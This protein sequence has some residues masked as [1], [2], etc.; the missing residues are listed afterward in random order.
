MKLKARL[1]VIVTGILIVVVAV[2][3]TI[4]LSRASDIVVG[5]SRRSV[6]R[7]GAQETALI[8]IDC[9]RYMQLLRTVVEIMNDFENMDVNMRRERYN[10]ILNSV[11][12]SEEQLVAVFSVWLPDALDGMDARYAGETGYTADGQYAPYFTRETG[13][14]KYLTYFNVPF[15]VKTLTGPRADKEHIGNPDPF[16]IKGAAAYVIRI[17]VPVISRRT[18]KVVGLVGATINIDFMQSIVEATINSNDD[19]AAMTVYSDNGT[20]VATGYNPEHI[21]K[22]LKDAEENLYHENT[23]K[24]MDAVLHGQK[25]QLNESLTA[26]ATNLEINVLPFTISETGVSWAVMIGTPQNKI[27]APVRALTFYTIIIAVVVAVTVAVII[28][29]VAGNIAKPIIGMT[30]MAKA[31]ADLKFDIEIKKNRNDEI[32]DMQDA[33]RII[34]DNLQKTMEDINTELLGKQANIT[35]NLKSS[36]N[37]SSDGLTVITRH[38]DSVQKKTDIQMGSVD[39]TAESVEEIV[40]HI[41]SLEEAVEVQ[42]QSISKSSES[43]EYLVR[44]IDSVRTI[45]G[46]A[47]HTT[48]NLSASSEVGRKMLRQLTEELARIAEQSAFLE[49]ANST[50]VNI[51]SQTNIL[52]MNAAIEAAHAGESGKGFAVVAGEVRKLAESSNKESASISN[53][54]KAMRTGIEKIRHVS[55]QTV[56]TLESMFT[57][58]TAM[59]MSFNTVNAA[60]EAQASNGA[61]ILDAITVLRDTT[62]QV[63]GGSGEI[64]NQSGLIYKVVEKLKNISAEVKESFLDVQKAAKDIAVSLEIAK[65]IS[66]GR[67]LTCPDKPSL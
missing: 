11:I 19:I 60:V 30:G 16:T 23:D 45:V 40:K 55:D 29:F 43:I 2:L 1:C 59:R 52:A 54:I 67:F 4:I 50:L 35:S 24:V 32:G 13:A 34:K 28:F 42:G 61:Q 12:E 6:E 66:E 33:L 64:Q 15:S 31:L 58:V 39:E 63:R 47:S 25:I 27:L 41:N 7:L 57:E 51:A 46:Q 14:L 44:D 17:I 9:E 3:S 10:E 36:I 62:E 20:I 37:K 21:G 26:L 56:G 38:M 8:R 22:L 53:E 49:E 65:K 18:G 48:S 5:I